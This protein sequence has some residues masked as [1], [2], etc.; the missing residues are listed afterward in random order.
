MLIS[1]IAWEK[2]FHKSKQLMMSN[3]SAKPESY[4]LYNFTSTFFPIQTFSSAGNVI[5]YTPI[6]GTNRE[7]YI[8]HIIYKRKKTGSSVKLTPLRGFLL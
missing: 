3:F 7:K 8:N 1:S 6:Q 5:L 2:S 4:N